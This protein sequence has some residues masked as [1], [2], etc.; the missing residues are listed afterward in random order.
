MHKGEVVEEGDHESLMRARGTYYGLV[1]QQNL[2]RAEEEEQLAFE[3]EESVGLVLAHQTDENLLSVTRKRTSTVV[4]LTPSVMAQL[5]GKNK[6]STAAGETDE[7]DD[8]E[9]KK[10]KVKNR[11]NFIVNNMI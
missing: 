8:D 7:E 10:K 11:I 3:R 5:Y 6:N 9:T 4:S 1:E 2:R